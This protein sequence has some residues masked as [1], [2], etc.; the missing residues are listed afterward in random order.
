MSPR[1][2]SIDVIRRL[3]EQG[4]TAFWAGGCVRDLLLGRPA[5]DFD[6]ATNATPAEVR[7][8]FGTRRTLAVGESFGVMI[9]LG[10]K[11]AGQ[12]EVATFRLDGTYAD[13][14]RPDHVEFCDAEHDAQRRDFTINGMFYDPLT[15]T[16]HDFVGG[17]ADLQRRVVRAIGNPIERMT[18]DKL[19]MLRAIRFAAVL[20]FELDSETA[21][22]VQHMARQLVV[23][24]SERIAQE[25]QKCL[26]HANRSIALEMLR[27]LDLLPIILPEVVE[28]VI[29]FSEERWNLLLHSLKQV[30]EL[31][32][33]AA[34]AMV[35]RFVP[36]PTDWKKHDAPGHGTVQDICKRLRLSNDQLAHICWLVQN[37]NMF[38]AASALPLAQL[39]RLLVSPYVDD[40]L[41]IERTWTICQGDATN[42]FDWVENYRSVT[43]ASQID[44]TELLTGRDLIQLG[45]QPGPYFSEWLT[46]IR[47]AQLNEQIEHRDEAVKLLEQLAGDK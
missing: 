6:V 33:E 14:R 32:F 12:V 1:E 3:R 23:V 26:R 21:S 24:S 11:S 42:E 28:T 13:G 8:V 19:R 36:A 43:P 9:V 15:E 20:D 31:S 30:P 2:F 10:P 29:H 37:R 40:L 39:K 46:T 17:K 27:S 18:E 22:A 41:T 35:L 44:P 4:F 38:D 16:V 25:L 45:H 5:T 7:E 47:D 34:M